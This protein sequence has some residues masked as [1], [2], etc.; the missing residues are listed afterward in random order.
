MEEIKEKLHQVI[1][2]RLDM[3]INETNYTDPY[4]VS[5]IELYESLEEKS[6]PQQAEHSK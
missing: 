4:I 5:Y 1:L 6:V 2:K 3:A